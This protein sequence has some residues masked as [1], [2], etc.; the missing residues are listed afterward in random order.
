MLFGISWVV[1]GILV[2]VFLL[3]LKFRHVRHRFLA[4]VLV[5]L[6]LFFYLTATQ[7]FAEKDVN[8]KS[9]DGLVTAGRVYGA[10]LW[11]ATGNT[12]VILG[13]AIKMD[14]IGNSSLSMQN[15]TQTK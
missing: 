7:L 4:V 14:W 1:I 6:L 2:V 13:N 11:H 15:K 8:L 5:L 3:L 10:W 9:F 12:R